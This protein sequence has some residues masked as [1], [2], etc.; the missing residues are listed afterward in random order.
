MTCSGFEKYQLGDWTDA[1]FQVHLK[2]CAECRQAIEDDEK[3]MQQSRSLKKEIHAPGLWGRIVN[4][5]QSAQ[6]PKRAADNY[7]WYLGIAA[8]VLIAV[9]VGLAIRF[10]GRPA[11]TGLL[12]DSALQRVEVEEREYEAAITD[13]EKTVSPKLSSLDQELNLL[14]RDRL[15][16]IDAQ[17]ER[18]K[19]ALAT[20][21]ANAHIRRYLLAALKDKKETLKEINRLEPV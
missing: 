12:A 6:P 13:L 4:D 1:L 21:P 5:L 19:E 10:L 17:I 18:C 2:T 16:T 9:G 11:D 7:R 8:V 15:E 20:N 14:Y 3:L